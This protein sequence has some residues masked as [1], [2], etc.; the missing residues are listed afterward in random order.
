MDCRTPGF[1]VWAWKVWF[2]G[3][4]STNPGVNLQ[5]QPQGFHENKPRAYVQHK[6]YDT[7][8]HMTC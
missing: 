8:D 5:L 1:P 2:W 3:N 4:A 6:T 7:L